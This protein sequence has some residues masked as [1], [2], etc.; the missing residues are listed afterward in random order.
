[1][2]NHSIKQT[3]TRPYEL[4]KIYQRFCCLTGEGS[5]SMIYI[6]AQTIAHQFVAKKPK[7]SGI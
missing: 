4:Y 3:L 6:P 2:Q 1:M 5:R 7:E